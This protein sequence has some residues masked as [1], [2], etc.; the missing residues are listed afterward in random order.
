MAYNSFAGYSSPTAN[1]QAARAYMDFLKDKKKPNL[2]D[3]LSPKTPFGLIPPDPAED[4]FNTK[5][6]PNYP[7]IDTGKLEGPGANVGGGMATAA[8]PR[9]VS[10]MQEEARSSAPAQEMG[11]NLA[12]VKKPI[13]MLSRIGSALSGVK[14]FAV[15]QV[16]QFANEQMG[17]ETPGSGSMIGRVL[18]AL[19]GAAVIQ[20]AGG[21]AGAQVAT[22][23]AGTIR[24]MVARQKEEERAKMV[25]A[26]E[27][28]D[29][30][31]KNQNI[32]SQIDER[33]NTGT[34][35]LISEGR[36]MLG[37]IK[38]LFGGGK[39]PPAFKPTP[40]PTM[41]FDS[42]GGPQSAEYQAKLYPIATSVAG[43]LARDHPEITDPHLLE[44]GADRVL[45]SYEETASL[46][47]NEK[48]TV[49]ATIRKQLF[50][51][52]PSKQE[53]AEAQADEAV[54][55]NKAPGGWWGDLGR[56]FWDAPTEI[57]ERYAAQHNPNHTIQNLFQYSE[58]G[59]QARYGRRAQEMMRNDPDL[60]RRISSLAKK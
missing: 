25:A 13:G 9:S 56:A 47:N 58:L 11:H 52:S 22:G 16:G 21:Q 44:Q 17:T 40:G 53:T 43:K 36:G 46:G 15:G 34:A 5:V 57:G 7:A 26:N 24:N 51:D 41:S 14:D 49:M 23:V 28:E 48:N 32:R 31:L 38:G 19:A 42:K 6:M 35:K 45:N 18:R 8:I 39:A 20:G 30:A 4:P 2:I 50:P 33:S 59:G 54:K 12:D 3:T 1:L 60:K 37:K 10:A 27:A 55:G 29:R